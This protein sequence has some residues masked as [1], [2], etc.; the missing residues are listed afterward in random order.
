MVQDPAQACQAL[1]G[2]QLAPS[3]L[4]LPNGGVEL[5]SAVLVRAA[6]AGNASGEYCRVTG[7]IRPVTA[8]APEIRFQVNLPTRWNGKAVQFGGGG[9]DG[10]IP[11]TVGVGPHGI[12]G[13]PTPLARGFITAADDSG[14]QAPNID[15]AS[16]ASNDEAVD[17]YAGLHVRKTRDVVA[18]LAQRRYGSPLRR[19]YFMGGSTGGRE[20]LTAALRFPDAY[21]GVVSHYPTANFMGL[22]LW[23][24]A[25]AHAVYPNDSA[26]WIPPALVQRIANEALANC[27]AL[28]GA[29]D[30]I[31]SNMAAC[32]ARSAALLERLK[33]RNGETGHPPNC[34]TAAQLRTIAVYHEGYTLPYE[35]ANG[36]RQ[37][38]GYNSLEGITMQLGSEARLLDPPPTP[39]NAHHVNRA[40]QFVKYFVVRDPRF[41]LLTLDLQAPGRWL[42]RLQELSAKIDASNPDF[43]RFAGHGGKLLLVQGLDD[44]SVSPYANAR[45]YRSIVQ[46]M[47]QPAA[48]AFSRF[49]MVPG[50][51]HGNGKFRLA[52][53]GLGELDRWADAGVAPSTPVGVDANAA[54]HGRTRPMCVYPS[55]PRYLGSGSLDEARNYACVAE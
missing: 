16:F 47:G 51:A 48:D 39:R 37:Y 28:D 55:W 9:Y 54:N 20:A 24:V 22:R 52:W 19:M 45:F 29:A 7:A 43:S 27:D 30:G 1:A 11:D 42:P 3:Q 41:H 49:Y 10:V 26:G 13:R 4:S 8:Q 44:P 40:D 46:R 25:L 14:H 5:R 32:R 12:P 33:C 23:G 35:L 6:E 38:E 17:N 36:I 15:D 34:L 18:A 2:V 53:D 31:V 50:L 21:D